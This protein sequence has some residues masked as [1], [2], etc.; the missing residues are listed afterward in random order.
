MDHPSAPL[1]LFFSIYHWMMAELAN[2]LLTK[3]TLGTSIHLIFGPTI[4]S[5]AFALLVKYLLALR[6][7]PVC[8]F[9]SGSLLILLASWYVDRICR[10]N[11][12][13]LV[14]CVGLTI[15]FCAVMGIV[16]ASE[17]R[18]AGNLP[19]VAVETAITGEFTVARD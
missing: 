5:G 19:Q 13:L 11:A 6:V 8:K 14:R 7:L 12:F 4:L 17:D 18:F 3:M 9:V 1:L 16:I 2:A 10:N 15:I